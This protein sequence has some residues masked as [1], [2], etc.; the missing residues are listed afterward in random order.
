MMKQIGVD[1]RFAENGAVRVFRIFLD[2]TWI[3]VEQGRQWVDRMGRHVLI[4]LPDSDA[5]EICLRSD[6]MT[7]QVAPLENR[8]QHLA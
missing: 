4:M 3:S 7:W 8:T 1:C 5:V 6:T 2:Q